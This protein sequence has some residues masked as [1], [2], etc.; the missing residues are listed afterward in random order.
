MLKDTKALPPVEEVRRKVRTRQDLNPTV[1][2][3]VAEWMADFLRRQRKID[4]TTRRSYEAHIRLYFTP[5]LADVRLD[6]LRG[7]DVAGMF[8][9]IEEFNDVITTARAGGAPEDRAKVRYRRPVGPA[10]MYRIRANM[11]NVYASVPR[12]SPVMAWTPSHT[13]AFLAQA[14][15]HRLSAPFPLIALRGL[16]PGEAVGL[17]WKDVDLPVGTA[18][19]IG[20]SPSWAGSRCRAG[21]RP[22]PATALLRWMRDTVTARERPWEPRRARGTGGGVVEASGVPPRQGN[23]PGKTPGPRAFHP[24]W[25]CRADG[26]HANGVRNSRGLSARPTI[27]TSPI[28]P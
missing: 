21:R 20:R 22:R 14:A 3:A 15:A 25:A 16:R 5:Y 4:A 12:L 7:S 1:T 26:R 19:C 18:G 6:R 2:V 9:V 28:H 13:F 17:R 27:R 11:I 23:L 10:T 24:P 8:D